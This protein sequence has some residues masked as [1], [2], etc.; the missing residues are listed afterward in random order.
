MPS[1]LPISLHRLRIPF[2]SSL[3]LG[4]LAYGFAITN[5][6]VNHDEV[7]TLFFKGGTF[8]LGRW[9][10]AILE[11]IF[12]N[13]SMPWIY[14]IITVVL[15]AA[16]V[17]MMVSLF[18]IRNRLLQARLGGTVMVFPS[19]IGLFGYMFTSASFGLSFFLAVL[20]VKLIQKPKFRYL[21]AAGACLVLSLSIYQSYISVAASLLVLLLI[22]G[23]VMKSRKAKKKGTVREA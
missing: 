3:I 18:G 20:S 11:L 9:G 10:L 5:K 2:L 16:A 1:A 15:V 14:G 8:S 19:L 7:F 13:Y 12:P 17:C 21:L 4:L 22:L 6:L 23:K